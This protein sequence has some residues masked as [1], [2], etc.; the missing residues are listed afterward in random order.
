MVAMA[1]PFYKA[2]LRLSEPEAG[3]TMHALLDLDL[4]L[5]WIVLLLFGGLLACLRTSTAPSPIKVTTEGPSHRM[6]TGS[7]IT[8]QESMICVV[9]GN[10]VD[11]EERYYERDAN[12]H[13][14][15]SERFG[16]V[17]SW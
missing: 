17:V 4:V 3:E 13:A 9:A 16:V 12:M 10:D 5:S 11:L 7:E 14:Y 6:R 2:P 15:S 1:N 8:E